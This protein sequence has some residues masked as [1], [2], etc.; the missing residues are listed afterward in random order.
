MTPVHLQPLLAALYP[1]PPASHTGARKP[2]SIGHIQHLTIAL[3]PHLLIGLGRQLPMTHQSLHLRHLFS[4]QSIGPLHLFNT[5]LIVPVLSQVIQVLVHIGR[6]RLALGSGALIAAG[7]LNRVIVQH[8]QHLLLDHLL[9]LLILAE[10]LSGVQ[11]PQ[12][13]AIDIS[14]PGQSGQPRLLLPS[15][16]I[17]L[18]LL[19]HIHARRGLC[20]STL[21]VRQH[22]FVVVLGRRQ[23]GQALLQLAQVLFVSGLVLHGR[24][25][26]VGIYAEFVADRRRRAAADNGARRSGDQLALR[27]P[28]RSL[29]HGVGRL[30][31]CLLSWGGAY[32]GLDQWCV[33]T[34]LERRV[35]QLQS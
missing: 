34:A 20:L 30:Q 9:G 19:L 35:R 1:V 21:F 11:R 3:L 33:L 15:L 6:P 24:E 8:A 10:R 5:K 23:F 28:K 29:E 31:F 12:Y 32:V 25:A 18:V 13:I 27:C 14:G 26:L 22:N 4:K 2:I 17:S 16:H 7:I